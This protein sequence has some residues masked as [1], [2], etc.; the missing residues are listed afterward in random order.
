MAES[1]V[2]VARERDPPGDRP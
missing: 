2:Q 1:W